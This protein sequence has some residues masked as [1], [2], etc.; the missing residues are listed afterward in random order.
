[1]ERYRCT[2]CQQ[3]EHGSQNFDFIGYDAMK[4]HKFLYWIPTCP[5]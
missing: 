1:M 4:R 5:L 2:H 3:V